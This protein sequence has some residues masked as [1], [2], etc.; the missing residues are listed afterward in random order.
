MHHHPP[1][2]GKTLKNLMTA[3]AIKTTQTT[4]KFIV[5]HYEILKFSLEYVSDYSYQVDKMLSREEGKRL[6]LKND[7]YVFGQNKYFPTTVPVLTKI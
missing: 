6:L 2:E 4:W 3:S 1:S 7:I 5:V